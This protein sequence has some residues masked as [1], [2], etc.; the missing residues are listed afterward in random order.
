MKKG[1]RNFNCYSFVDS[2]VGDY[3]IVMM[4]KKSYVY[5]VA[6]FMS[7]YISYNFCTPFSK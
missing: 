3:H 4:I 6:F 2:V 1:N 7:K 5:F